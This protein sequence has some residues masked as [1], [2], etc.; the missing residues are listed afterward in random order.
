MK[1]S[2]TLKEA[3]QILA[4]ID[5]RFA[6]VGG[7]AASARGEVRFTRDI[8]LAVAVETDAD[9][10]QIIY[11]FTTKGYGVVATVEQ[12]ATKRLAT[13]RLQH[14]TGVVCDLVF[15]TCGVEHEVVEGAD[16]LELFPGLKVPTA[17]V[18]SL[19]AMKV[20]SSSPERPRDLGDIQA[21]LRVCPNFDEEQLLK[22]LRKIT[23]RGYSRGQ[24]LVEKWRKV[25]R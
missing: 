10:E 12:K 19:L 2:T 22:L 9:A 7:L 1:L 13:A 5:S 15:A 23:E 24:D 3:C 25:L 17:T 18:E 21:M 8:D 11:A 14:T 16:L 6:V 4:S 20:L